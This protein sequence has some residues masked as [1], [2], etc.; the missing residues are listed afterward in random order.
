M[1]RP[2]KPHIHKEKTYKYE[3]Q[4]NKTEIVDIRCA[5]CKCG[6]LMSAVPVGRRPKID[7]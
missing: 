7:P 5:Y 1:A 6:E 2:K 3:T 4:T